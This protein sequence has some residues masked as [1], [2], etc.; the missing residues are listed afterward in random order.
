MSEAHRLCRHF[1]EL[2]KE[3]I[4]F[5]QCQISYLDIVPQQ[6]RCTHWG[7]LGEEYKS[8]FCIIFATSFEYIIIFKVK[9]KQ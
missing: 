6:V 4:K 7:K 8:L 1:I 5:Y 3:L 9:S 2:Q